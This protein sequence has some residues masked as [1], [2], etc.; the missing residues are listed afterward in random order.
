MQPISKF[1]TLD[2]ACKSTTA[3]R[4]DIANV[5]DESAVLNMQAL[6]YVVYD[7]CCKQF[8]TKLPITS[9]FRSVKLNKKIGGSAT[10]QHCKGQA[11]DI[12]C[13]LLPT[14][15]ITNADVFNYIR[16]NC[17]FDQLIWEF[18]NK[19]QPDW[20]HVSY[21]LTNNRGQVLIAVKE[22]NKTTYKPY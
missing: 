8:K 3:I 2:E 11:V 12:D 15:K 17:K 14:K 22:N 6:C 10:S 4:L 1:L 20:V 13:D 9:F 16:M 21:S 7:V 19:T 18:G 5:P